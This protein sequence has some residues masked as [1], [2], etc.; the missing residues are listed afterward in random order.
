MFFKI[1][2]LKNL[3]IFIRKDFCWTLFLIKLQAWR[4]ALLLKRD[5]NTDITLWILRNY[6]EHFFIEHLLLIILFRNF[7]VM[8]EFFGQLWVQNWYFS[9]FYAFIT[10]LLESGVHDYFVLVFTLTFL[11]SITFARI[12]TSESEKASSIIAT[13]P[14]NLLWKMRIWVFW[15]LCFAII[16]LSKL[17]CKDMV[18]NGPTEKQIN[19]EVHATLNHG[20]VWKLKVY[21]C[22]LQIQI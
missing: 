22:K 11:V 5:T 20:L 16:F 7:Y 18:E 8:I 6:W 3:T 4:P 19:V 15:I 12:T 2:I 21:R 17:L 9:N 14:G 10:L 1:A 13:F